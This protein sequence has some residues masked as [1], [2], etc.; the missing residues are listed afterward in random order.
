MSKSLSGISDVQGC[1]EGEER[2]KWWNEMKEILG[3]T[4]QELK[5]KEKLSLIHI[6]GQTSDFIVHT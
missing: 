1:L 6:L 3:I 5:E 2:E 4:E